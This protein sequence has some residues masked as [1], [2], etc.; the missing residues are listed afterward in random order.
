[1]R[2]MKKFFALMLAMIMAMAMTVTAFADE[3]AH[4]ITIT[5]PQKGITYKAY[6]LFNVTKAADATADSGYS[7]YVD[8]ATYN[9][10]GEAFVE[11]LTDN[12]VTLTASADGSRYNVSLETGKAAQLAAALK[13]TTLPMSSVAT[14]SVPEGE[15]VTEETRVVLNV[16][17]DGYFFVTSTL[18]SLCALNT[19]APSQSITDKNSLPSIEKTVREDS[20]ET[21][22][23]T[24]NLDVIDT[25]SYRLTV[26]TGTSVLTC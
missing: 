17:T 12:G 16:V 23:A 18:G 13:N 7:Y 9:G 6:K 10:W 5:N 21:Y 20:N 22:G 2:K 15:T 11:V 4:T 24:A 25:A 8:T 3:P 1:M 14:G 19:S 26:N